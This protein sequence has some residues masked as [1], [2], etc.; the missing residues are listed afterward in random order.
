MLSPTHRLGGCR[1]FKDGSIPKEVQA[2]L[3]TSGAGGWRFRGPWTLR[4]WKDGHNLKVSL[5]LPMRAQDPEPT[6]R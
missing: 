3:Q 1:L 6:W 5:R 4:R 2:R